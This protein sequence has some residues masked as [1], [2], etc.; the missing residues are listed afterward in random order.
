[1]TPDQFRTTAQAIAGKKWKT[2]LCPMIGKCRSQVY[3]YANGKREVPETVEKLM[4][5]MLDRQGD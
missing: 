1:M 2:Q 4:G 3:E 5:M